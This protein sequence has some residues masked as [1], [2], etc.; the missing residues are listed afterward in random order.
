MATENAFLTSAHRTFMK[1]DHI[2]GHKIS[3]SQSKQ[4]KSCKIHPLFTKK[5]NWKQYLLYRKRINTIMLPLTLA[6]RNPA[7]EGADKLAVGLKVLT[8][9]PCYVY[10][11]WDTC[12]PYM[13]ESLLLSPLLSS[14]S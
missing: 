12:L 1:V 5:L 7:E 14:P 9:P 6:T 13:G 11:T 4:F 3:L 2:L 8:C 10:L